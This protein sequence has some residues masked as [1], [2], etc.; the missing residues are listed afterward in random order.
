[1]NTSLSRV[2]IRQLALTMILIGFG[3]AL[4]GVVQQLTWNGKLFWVHPVK[5]S[6][7][8]GPYVNHNHFAGLMVMLIPLAVGY[9]FSIGRRRSGSEG[10]EGGRRAGMPREVRPRQA[11]LLFMIAVMLQA[12]LMSL[13]RGGALAVFLALSLMGLAV[14]T[15]KQTRNRIWIWA[16]TVSFAVAVAFWLGVGK[17]LERLG[18]LWFIFKDPSAQARTEIWADTV[19]MFSEMPVFGSGLGSFGSA[20]DAFQSFT[21]VRYLR[22]LYAH[23]DPLQLLSEG[24]LI[25]F[26]IVLAASIV[27]TGRLWRA[28]NRRRDRE[29]IY[30]ALGGLTGMAAFVFHTFTTTGFHITANAL[31]FAVLAGLTLKAANSRV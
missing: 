2:R 27:Y 29:I 28:V 26:G 24:G 13:S 3:L 7:P 22:W 31:T 11:L 30:L 4:F 25:V 8:F 16:G 15:G 18:T 23:S 12:L 21:S 14:G 19:R 1:V 20:F 5:S 10:D 6:N 17:A 9:L